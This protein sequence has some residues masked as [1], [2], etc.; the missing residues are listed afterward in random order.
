MFLDNIILRDIQET[1]PTAALVS[2]SPQICP[3]EFFTFSD[4]S[5]GNNLDY[6]W[7]FGADAIPST[8]TFAGPHEVQFTTP[9]TKTIILSLSNSS[10]T[11]S[12][13]MTVDVS[14]QVTSSFQFALEP[15]TSYQAFTFTNMAMNADLLL[16]D[17]GDGNTSNASQPTHTYTMNGRYTI[18]LIATNACGA[19]TSTQII[20]I[21]NVGIGDLFPNLD[22]LLQP[23]PGEGLF[24]LEVIGG[25][26]VQL[27]ECTVVTLQGQK[28]LDFD[29]SPWKGARK[30]Q[31]DLRDHPEG[32]YFLQIRLGNEVQSM[33]LVKQ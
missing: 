14:P 15:D 13:T 27:M 10:G 3:G 26:E 25:E 12:D 17:F 32:I 30:H 9:G 28:L 22:I 29:L 16:W 21:T 5:S 31:I 18:S 23:N 4:T 2:D 24:S 8:A 11:S 20:D 1:P 19:D 6:S 33:K 7:S